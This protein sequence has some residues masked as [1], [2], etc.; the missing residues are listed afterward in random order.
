MCENMDI[1]NSEQNNIRESEILEKINAL[2]AMFEQKILTD[3][4]KNQKYDEMHS[5]MLKYQDDIIGKM[6]DPLLKSLI[7]LV[8]SI[9][10]DKRYYSNLDTEISKE[11]IIELLNGITEQVNAVLF[12]YEIEEY[13]G[14]IELVNPKEQKMFKTIATDNPDLNNHVA[15]I[16]NKGYK[17]ADKIIRMEKVNIYKYIEKK[18]ED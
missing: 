9:E 8:D 14:G 15:E 3:E 17:K 5:L 10:R 13:S 1:Q 12:D 2:T 16:I 7:L 4:W 11:D 6:I 18:E